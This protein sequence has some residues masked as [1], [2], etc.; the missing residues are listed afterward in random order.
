MNTDCMLRIALEYA[1]SKMNDDQLDRLVEEELCL[2][3][4]K[5][6]LVNLNEDRIREL[7]YKIGF[8]QDFLKTI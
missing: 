4:K 2:E 8:K 1:L 5:Q 3:E 6:A 7:L